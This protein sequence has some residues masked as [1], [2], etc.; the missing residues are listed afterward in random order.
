ML[1]E[2]LPFLRWHRLHLHTSS[3]SPGLSCIDPFFFGSL[4]PIASGRADDACMSSA[5]ADLKIRLRTMTN[6]AAENMRWAFGA[7][8]LFNSAM[9]LGIIAVRDPHS[10]Q[11]SAIL[12]DLEAYC[13][14]LR[15]D[16][17]LNEFGIAELK[18]IELCVSK[19]RAPGAVLSAWP[20]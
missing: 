6:T 14:S 5:L 1:D 8:N 16:P 18:V 12:E 10:I 20:R 15:R 17:W 2:E 4:L 19:V 7:H 13:E 3:I 11:T 9:I